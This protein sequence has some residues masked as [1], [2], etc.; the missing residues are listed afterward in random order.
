M[1]LRFVAVEI[2]LYDITNGSTK[3]L[4]LSN[5]G[6]LGTEGGEV[7]QFEPV[8]LGP[9]VVGVSVVDA[10]LHYGGS[11]GGSGGGKIEFSVNDR[12]LPYLD[13]ASLGRPCRV[14]LAEL[15]DNYDIIG[16]NPWQEVQ[17]AYD[18]LVSDLN[19]D[20][21]SMRADISMR[22]RRGAL[23][24]PLVSEIY[25]DD[26]PVGV[27]G[28]PKPRIFGI[29]MSCDPVLNGFVPDH[30]G[31]PEGSPR[32]DLS[33]TGIYYIP[34]VRVDGIPWSFNPGAGLLP[35]QW[36]NTS[37]Y[38]IFGGTTL[39]GEIRADV[40]AQPRTS[41][42]DYDYWP[43]NLLKLMVESKGQGVNSEN[44]S[45]FKSLTPYT[46]GYYAR[47]PINLGAALDEFTAG[48]GAIWSVSVITGEILFWVIAA[49]SGVPVATFNELNISSISMT[50]RIPPV[51]RLRVEYR[52]NWQ[53]CS[54]FATYVTD[55]EKAAMRAGGV[56][57]AV[58]GDDS[59]KIIEPDAIDMPLVRSVVLNE[60]EAL[61][62]RDR[63]WE[64][65]KIT[66]HLWTL[67]I[68]VDNG[69]PDLM[70]VVELDFEGTVSGLYRVVSIT[71]SIGGPLAEIVVWG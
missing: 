67:E 5:V 33:Y 14:Y 15:P 48:V 71:R 4:R 19:F 3:I 49:P 51:H 46:G 65:Y 60:S 39:G 70:D 63:L 61:A 37:Q 30:L 21:V 32:Y 44:I 8:L 31:I 45:E 9:V 18:G 66:R 13:F 56:V 41:D 52:R 22:D 59:L 11:A 10:I 69:I 68:V 55:A 25:P 42:I 17:L 34:E 53:P 38:L 35:G 2:D 40:Y 58:I 64:V 47:D 50:R 57:T 16:Q 54:R 1:T 20:P 27:K 36:Q 62:I 43:A 29:C 28:R 26:A 12:I 7:I 23:D 6:L 24:I